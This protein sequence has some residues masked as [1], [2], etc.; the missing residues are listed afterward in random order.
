M[1]S[2]LKYLQA[3]FVECLVKRLAADLGG[4]IQLI[5]RIF[6]ATTVPAKGGTSSE[7]ALASAP[8]RAAA[9]CKVQYQRRGVP[10]TQ[11][12]EVELGEI[13]VV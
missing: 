5:K 4:V 9:R 2:A 6:K 13:V 7:A 10:Q 1:E 11:G 12:V 3:V 8:I